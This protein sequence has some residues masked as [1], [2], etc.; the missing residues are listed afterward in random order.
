MSFVTLTP[1]GAQPNGDCCLPACRTVCGQFPWF[2]RRDAHGAINSNTQSSTMLASLA[3][4]GCFFLDFLGW[5]ADGSLKRHGKIQKVWG[6][7]R[8]AASKSEHIRTYQNHKFWQE[9]EHAG[10]WEPSLLLQATLLLCWSLWSNDATSCT[11]EL[12]FRLALS[13]TCCYS[14]L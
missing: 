10:R 14:M 12:L 2:P 8:H 7:L 3:S 1:D 9:A 13:C 6:I 5:S 4:H 11:N